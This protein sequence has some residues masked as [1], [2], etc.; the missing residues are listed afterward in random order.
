ML[1]GALF[2]ETHRPILAQKLLI[3]RLGFIFG[4]FITD[5]RFKKGL[6]S[7]FGAQTEPTETELNEFL[8]IFRFNDGRKI[9]HKLIRYM[10]E[11]AK[12]RSRWVEALQ[13]MDVPFRFINGLADPVSGVHLVRR[14]REVVPLQTDI[15]ELPEIGHYPHFEAPEI[16]LNYFFEFQKKI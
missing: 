9:A 1:N 3:S 15:V 16:V 7:V 4:K 10:T 2:P 12:Y 6:S 14:F 13:K 8:E 5:A 11:R